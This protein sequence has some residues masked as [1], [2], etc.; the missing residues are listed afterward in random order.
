MS[1]TLI[2]DRLMG[3]AIRITSAVYFID[4]FLQLHGDDVTMFGDGITVVFH[5]EQPIFLKEHNKS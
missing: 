3:G 5:L 1:K 4:R 2:W